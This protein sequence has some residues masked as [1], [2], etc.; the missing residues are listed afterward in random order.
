MSLQACILANENFKTIHN[1]RGSGH[2]NG[3]KITKVSFY[4]PNSIIVLVTGMFA[5][6]LASMDF[7]AI[8]TV[9]AVFM[10]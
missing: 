3:V 10:C 9:P 4:S 6:D 2:V 5:V 1:K 8:L 7:M